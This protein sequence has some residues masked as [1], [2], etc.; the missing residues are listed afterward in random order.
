MKK[1]LQIMIDGILNKNQTRDE[2]LDALEQQIKTTQ[3]VTP[4]ELASRMEHPRKY[5][6]PELISTFENMAKGQQWQH[7]EVL[8]KKDI[9]AFM[10]F[11][12]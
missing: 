10:I 6:F 4:E 2:W 9:Y 3:S 12:K 8:V 7:F 5:D 1:T 11:S